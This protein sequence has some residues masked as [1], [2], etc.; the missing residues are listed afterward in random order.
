M[1]ITPFSKFI[2]LSFVNHWWTMWWM[3]SHLILQCRIGVGQQG[4]CQLFGLSELNNS[5]ETTKRYSRNFLSDYTSRIYIHICLRRKKDSNWSVIYAT[6]SHSQLFV[7]FPFAFNLVVHLL[8]S[9]CVVCG[10]SFRTLSL[11]ANF[12]CNS[13]KPCK[14]LSQLIHTWSL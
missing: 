4:G 5:F 7:S 6:C 12:R 14:W 11:L 8:I 10:A 9:H 1:R 3:V 13:R 2:P